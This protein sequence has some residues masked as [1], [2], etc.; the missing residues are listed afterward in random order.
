M[1]T[2]APLYI[3]LRPGRRFKSRLINGWSG[4]I[5]AFRA[6]E[7]DG[8]DYYDVTYDKTPDLVHQCRRD[9][10]TPLRADFVARKVPA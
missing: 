8:Y 1:S 3:R 7:A 2:S 9:G 4:K 6:T 5:V 10:L